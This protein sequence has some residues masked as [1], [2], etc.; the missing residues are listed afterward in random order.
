MTTNDQPSF[1]NERDR[2]R[3]WRVFCGTR[4]A[5]G[6]EICRTSARRDMTVE[7]V[8]QA[9]VDLGGRLVL[10]ADVA[11]A[12][13]VKLKEHADMFKAL[14][15]LAALAGLTREEAAGLAQKGTGQ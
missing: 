6:L 3:I 8:I 4:Y 10:A 14:G 13:E 11:H 1:L 5:G 7:D 15:K 9:L 2:A 12:N